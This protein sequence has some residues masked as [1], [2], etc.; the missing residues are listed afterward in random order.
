[1]GGPFALGHRLVSGDRPAGLSPEGEPFG[2]LGK[3]LEGDHG[4]GAIIQHAVA[5]QQG[6]E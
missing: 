2:Q 4:A 1:M 6:D 3:A 5:D